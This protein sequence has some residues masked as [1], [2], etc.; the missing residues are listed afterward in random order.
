VP[1][2]LSEVLSS[3]GVKNTSKYEDVKVWMEPRE[4][5]VSGL[6]GVL[7]YGRYGLWDDPGTGK[8]L[9]AYLFSAVSLVNG[10][11][12]LAVMPPGLSDQYLENFI[13]TIGMALPNGA[14]LLNQSPKARLE[15]YEEWNKTGWP[16]LLVIGYQMFLRCRPYLPSDEYQTFICDEAH[17]LKNPRSSTH[18]VVK[19]FM[20][21]HNV[22]YLT[23]SPSPT[24]PE[25][26]YGLITLLNPGVYRSKR[27]FDRKHLIKVERDTVGFKNLNLLSENLYLRARRV[28]KEEVLDLKKPNII[29][30]AFSL[31]KSHHALYKKLVSERVLEANGE[32]ITALEAASL[33]RHAMCLVSFPNKYSDSKRKI[34]SNMLVVLDEIMDSINMVENKLIIFANYV[35]TVEALEEY[36]VDFNPAVIYGGSNTEEN[37]QKFINDDTCRVAVINPQA[38]G[39]GLD[40]FQHVCHNVAAFEPL[41]S[42]GVMDQCTSRLIRSGQERVV[43]VYLLKVS[44]T[45]FVKAY[46]TLLDRTKAL[47]QTVIKAGDMLNE[48]L[49]GE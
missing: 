27:A 33:R 4:H 13:D 41:T 1:T 32:L 47:K 23:G 15:K 16:D 44:G 30:K 28:T 3:A 39:A 12:V 49:G 35:P 22:L 18:K 11:K 8:S 25:D 29:P 34:K 48:L 20:Y 19:E 43:N 42:P 24:T 36:L 17:A 5:Q 46:R 45:L 37:K 6:I 10:R 14:A 31:D 38:G 7:K 9:I 2:T 40:G 26:A 21:D